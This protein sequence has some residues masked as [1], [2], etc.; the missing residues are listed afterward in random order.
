MIRCGFGECD[1]EGAVLVWGS[2]QSSERPDIDWT[3][4]HSMCEQ[5]AAD[6]IAADAIVRAEYPDGQTFAR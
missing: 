3:G 1:R 5:H 2:A 6:M 4:P